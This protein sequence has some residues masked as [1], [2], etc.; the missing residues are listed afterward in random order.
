VATVRERST[1]RLEP[2]RL[3]VA[4]GEPGLAT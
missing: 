2:V 4:R 1:R 3:R